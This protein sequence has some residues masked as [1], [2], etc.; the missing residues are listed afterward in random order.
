MVN[1][2]D[3][4]KCNRQFHWMSS[5][6]GDQEVLENLNQQMALF[7]GQDNE[8]KL[9]QEMLNSIEETMPPENSLTCR[10]LKYIS[11]LQPETV[12]EIGCANGRLYRQL[13]NY[14]YKGGYSGIEVANYIIEENQKYHP[15]ANWNYATAYEIPF[16]DGSF[17]VCFSF[18]VIEH[19]VY[20]E[21]ALQEMMRVIKP[22]GS[23][24]LIF[25]DFV[26]SGRFASQLLG[27][28]TS[29][30]AS[31][32]LRK[33]KLIDAVVSIYDSRVRLRNALKN[34]VARYGLFPV[35]LSPI[36]L[37]FPSVMGAD[38]DG[39][40]IA[41]KNELHQWGVKEGYSVDYPCGVEGEFAEH[42][43]M[44]IRKSEL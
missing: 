18:Y 5:V 1:L 37:S 44:S 26:Q 17:D 19:L 3:K 23:L 4:Y 32:K 24:I 28:S 34:A 16:P 38:V 15:E 36:C 42:A 12:L 35:N 29:G 33:G 6:T 43:F 20:P 7:Y 41:S 22:K 8:R 9:Y 25:P 40:Y 11:D 14:G 21:K 2:S 13:R 30:T 31:Q 39:I 10:F 27:L